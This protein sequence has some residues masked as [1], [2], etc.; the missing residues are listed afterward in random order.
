MI[1]YFRNGLQKDKVYHKLN[2]LVKYE[3]FKKF[4]TTCNETLNNCLYELYY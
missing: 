4:N 3:S 1:Y 2:L